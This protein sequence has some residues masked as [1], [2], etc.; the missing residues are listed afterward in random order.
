MPY[1]IFPGAVQPG[2]P[3]ELDLEYYVSDRVSAPNPRFEVET[4]SDPFFELPA[5]VTVIALHRGVLVDGKFYLEFVT[6]ADR[7]YYVQYRDGD[8][9]GA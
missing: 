7:T 3:L 6:V 8:V 2:Q 5:G 1:V 4:V 9:S